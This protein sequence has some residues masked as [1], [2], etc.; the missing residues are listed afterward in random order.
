VIDDDGIIA[1]GHRLTRVRL[2]AMRERLVLAIGSCS[3]TEPVD[4]LRALGWL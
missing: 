3:F 4:E 1:L 2:A